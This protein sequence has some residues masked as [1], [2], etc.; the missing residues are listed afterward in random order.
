M[1]GSK[2]PCPTVAACWS[3][4]MPRMRI[5]PPNSSGSVVPNSPAQSRTSGSSAIGTSNSSQ[6]PGPNGPRGYRAASVRAA[7][8]ASVACTLPP[9][10]RHSR[11]LSTVPKASRPPRPRRARPQRDRAAKLFSSPRNKDRATARCVRAMAG[12]WPACRSAAQASAVRRSCQTMALWI[13]RP[14]AAV[15]N[16]RGLALIGDAERC[17][18]L[19]AARRPLAM[20][21]RTVATVVDQMS[22]GSCSTRPGAG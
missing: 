21:A 12:S 5:G 20:A 8:V 14:V 15:P 4:A 10:R 17:N 3:P 22:S 9:V 16:D 19:G 2:Q 7:L 13:G 1:P 18:I 11:K 6:S